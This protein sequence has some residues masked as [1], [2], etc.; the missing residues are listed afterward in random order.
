M[1]TNLSLLLKPPQRSSPSP[2]RKHGRCH[3]NFLKN[4]NPMNHLATVQRLLTHQHVSI[5][6]SGMWTEWIQIL[7]FSDRSKEAV[8]EALALTVSKVRSRCCM[9]QLLSCLL[10][11]D[12]MLLFPSGMC[13]WLIELDR[14]TRV[15]FFFWC[16]FLCFH[17]KVGLLLCDSNCNLFYQDPTSYAYQFQDDSFL[18]PKTFTEFV[19]PAK[20]ILLSIC[21]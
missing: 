6:L 4:L 2:E 13:V 12:K 9:M 14:W 1:I 8:L 19:R 16:S 7:I 3:V 10:F 15:L 20:Y 11:V 17:S 18:S 21:I 5:F